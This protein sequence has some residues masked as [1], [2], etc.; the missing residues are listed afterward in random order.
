MIKW[1]SH[2]TNK[3]N[4][5]K[6]MKQIL[7]LTVSKPCSEKFNQF[8]PTQNGGFCNSC[9][10]EVI[11]FRNI[12][13]KELI[14]FLKDKKENTCGFFNKTQLKSYTSE[15]ITKKKQQH[16][17]LKVMGFA[18][19]S[20]IS[21]NNIQAQEHKPS[22][23]IVQ[24]SKTSKTTKTIKSNTMVKGVIFDE[25]SPLHGANIVLK[26]TSIGTASNFDGE[27]EFPQALKKGDVLVVSYLGF[28]TQ[29]ITIHEDQSSLNIQ[30]TYDM[31]CVLMG[32]VEVNQVY[33]SKPTLWKRIKSIF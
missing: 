33:K 15:F 25:S 30:M 13:D 1:M 5:Y 3:I 2:V 12:S 18:F 7:S 32:E 21:I 4:K 26:G 29:N 17:F 8:K 16:T 22:T 10:K 24:K 11:D 23:V 27:F 20:M 6:H 28:E 19:L 9:S 14:N 31:S